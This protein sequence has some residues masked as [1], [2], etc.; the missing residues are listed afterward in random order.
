MHRIT[1]K[2]LYIYYKFQLPLIF[3]NKLYNYIYIIYRLQYKFLRYF[4]LY[5]Y[6]TN[7]IQSNHKNNI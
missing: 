5:K 1:F 3:M 4:K 6:I 7:K 2:Y